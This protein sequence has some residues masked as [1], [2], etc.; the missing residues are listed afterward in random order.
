VECLKPCP[1][2]RRKVRLSP[3]SAT[4]ALF[5]HS[6]TF[7]DSVDRLLDFVIVPVEAELHI[8][9]MAGLISPLL[10]IA[11]FS[12][13]QNFAQLFFTR[14]WIQ[15]LY[16]AA[17]TSIE[18]TP[19]VI[20]YCCCRNLCCRVF[21]S[22]VFSLTYIV[23]CCTVYRTLWAVNI[24]HS[25]P[26]NVEFWSHGICPCFHG[27]TVFSQKFAEFGAGWW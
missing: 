12:P 3:N 9:T 14:W 8:R 10:L 26:R 18:F 20:R 22:A 24:I 17:D 13:E 7:C 23:W 16:V 4:V 1:H 25:F 6:L 11:G 2:C 5:C 19:L 21:E 15:S 27:I